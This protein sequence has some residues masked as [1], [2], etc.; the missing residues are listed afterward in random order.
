MQ[1]YLECYPC[2]L[3][4]S[5]DAAR[6]AGATPAQEREIVMEA[7]RILLSLPES[8]TPPQ[9]SM[10]VHRAVREITG[11][12]DPYL[13]AKNESTRK[14]LALLPR[15]R[16]ILENA[17]DPLET[18]ARLSIAGNIM[19]FGPNPQFDLW[20]VVVRVLEQPLAI[21]DLEPLR[22]KLMDAKQVLFLADN[23]GETVF[24]RLLIE[25]INPKVIYVVKGGPVLNDA[26]YEDAVAAGIDQVA[27][28]VDNGTDITGTIL[29]LCPLAFQ[30]RFNQAELILSKGMGN[31]E[32]L[33]TVAGPIYHLM[34]VKCPVIGMDV[35]APNG[36]IVV[37]QG[38][39]T[40]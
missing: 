25:T 22:K 2:V 21:N 39:T 20:E 16:V 13:E 24:D 9:I 11:N 15:L 19:D 27:E 31:Y 38:L 36:S 14:A 18:A 33:S 34:Q 6:R 35:G 7:L 4:Q 23:A 37:K 10:H 8:S 40:G 12:P 30:T 32:T 1:A 3:R 29:D 17:I 26:T 5:I 28:I